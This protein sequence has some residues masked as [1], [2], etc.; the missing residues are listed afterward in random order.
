V[1]I[2]F[3]DYKKTERQLYLAEEIRR[4]FPLDRKVLEMWGRIAGFFHENVIGDLAL[5]GFS[6][7]AQ[8]L[9]FIHSTNV[10]ADS[11]RK[12]VLER[13]GRVVWYSGEDG[14]L[15]RK[16]SDNEIRINYNQL[17]NYL[18]D[19]LAELA[20]YESGDREE[21]TIDD[22]F[23]IL[24]M[25]SENRKAFNR[26]FSFKKPLETL[27]VT[28]WLLSV[29]EDERES[30]YL[31]Y[32]I[33]QAVFAE[34][35]RDMKNLNLSKNQDYILVATECYEQL[36]STTQDIGYYDFIQGYLE[37][38]VLALLDNHREKKSP[39]PIPVIR[40]TLCKLIL[41]I[42]QY[43]RTGGINVRADADGV[44]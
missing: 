19:L 34:L 22:V 12:Q 10:G 35:P 23:E 32:L 17:H 29:A 39:I 30:E 40:D 24:S 31:D 3:V 26:S 6:K 38:T 9:V 8:S 27:V 44:S 13:G 18:G 43:V 42:Q 11:L 21:L 1:D 41:A 5:Y 15:A 37:K 36:A 16:T 25:G 4:R 28:H 33:E 14:F 7:P 20:R 2:L